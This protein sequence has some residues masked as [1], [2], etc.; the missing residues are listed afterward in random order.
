MSTYLVGLVMMCSCSSSIAGGYFMY[1]REMERK[2]I[3]EIE[4]RVSGKDIF[5]YPECDYKGDEIKLP[6]ENTGD[7]AEMN[8]MAIK[9]IILPEGRKLDLFSKTNREGIKFQY[10]GPSKQRCVDG[11]SLKAYIP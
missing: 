10:K 1:Q 5:I 6:L 11:Q 4:T 9:S 3:E 2:R 8:D 7:V